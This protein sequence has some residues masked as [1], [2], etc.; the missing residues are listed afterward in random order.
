MRCC[1]FGWSAMVTCAVATVL[2]GCSGMQ[3]V[4]GV[5]GA[6]PQAASPARRAV[7]QPIRHLIVIVQ[8]HRTFEDLFS[9]YPGADAPG[10]GCAG[11]AAD[12]RGKAG[13]GGQGAC[14][15]GDTRVPL[16]ATRLAA[17]PCALSSSF[18]DYFSIAWDDGKMD[19]WNR[20]GRKA[21]LCPYAHVERRDTQRYW[22]LAKRF[23]LADHAFAST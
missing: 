11:S 8:Q 4:T 19:G 21:P 7:R 14:P 22:A 2:S 3:P 15:P 5:P 1:S 17:R 12:R 20:L 16:K 9:G 18:A 10:F 6:A 23:A 13:P